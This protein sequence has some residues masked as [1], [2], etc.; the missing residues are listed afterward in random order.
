MDG[1]AHEQG[2]RAVAERRGT[3]QREVRQHS[4][5][6]SRLGR[7]AANALDQEEGRAFAGA[8]SEESDELLRDRRQSSRGADRQAESGGETAEPA[9]LLRRGGDQHPHIRRIGESG[10]PHA[11]AIGRRKLQR[12][13]G[14]AEDVD[15]VRRLG[16]VAR[17]ALTPKKSEGVAGLE[18]LERRLIGPFVPSPRHCGAQPRRGFAL[19]D[20]LRERA[21]VGFRQLARTRRRRAVRTAFR[22]RAPARF[23]RA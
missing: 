2:G 20:S 13:R 12:Q 6:R 9:P 8:N 3:R 11:P 10:R 19:W 5:G 22:T 16:R 21:Q 1:L 23:F 18:R 7:V 15:E 4:H 17:S 14:R